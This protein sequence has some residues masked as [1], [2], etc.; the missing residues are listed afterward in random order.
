MAYNTILLKGENPNIEELEAN[1]A[2]TPGDLVEVMSTGKVRVHAGDEGYA[3]AIMIALESELE[4]KGITDAYAAGEQVRCWH[5][6]RGDRGYCRLADGENAAIGDKLASNGD[7][8]LKEYS[9]PE[10]AIEETGAIVAIAREAVNRS[11]SSGADTNTTGRIEV[12]FV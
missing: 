12:E 5:P 11:S 2:I 6:Q 7:G 1:A 3:M 10:S 9:S 8:F 4:G